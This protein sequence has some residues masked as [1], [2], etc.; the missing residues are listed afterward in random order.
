MKLGYNEATCMKRS[1]VE[2]DLKLCEKYGYDYIE[3]R[4]DMLKEYL[5]DHS[6][7]ELKGFFQTSH[8][9]PYAFNSIEDINFCGEQQWKELVDLFTFGCQVAQAI[10]NPYMIVVPTMGDDMCRKT[11]AEVFE[12]SVS[13]LNKLADIAQPYGVK[14]AFEPIGDRRWACNSIREAYEI[15]KAV[16]RE[17]VGLAVDCINVYLH[18][19]CADAGYLEEIPLDKIFVFHIND[20]EDLP[21]GVLDHCHRLFPG[22]GCIPITKLTEPLKRKGYDEIASLELFRPEYWEMDP[23]DV[24]RIGAEKSKQFL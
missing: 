20:C 11:E 24:I 4:L 21:L 14:L 2:N 22:D 17:D 5:K 6:I 18:D 23:E 12:D 3:L 13:V 8:L 16:D 9:K 15:V 1:S 19:K 7:E 10:G